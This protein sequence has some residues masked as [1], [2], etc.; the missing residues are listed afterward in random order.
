MKL[1]EL[2]S[3]VE[4]LSVQADVDMEIT[5]IYNDSRKV[6]SGGL[7]VAIP[8][9]KDDG[10]KYVKSALESGAAAVIAESP[11]APG[12]PCVVVE[13]ARRALSGLSANFFGRPSNS[14]TV[15]GVTGTNG[16]TT[17]AY[18]VK[19]MLEQCLEAP[20][21][22]IGTNE[23][24]VGDHIREASRTT[25]ESVE[26]H[27]IFSEMRAAGIKHVVMEVSS[28]AL[29]LK[30]VEDVCFEVGVFTNLTREH[31]DFHIT[32]EDYLNS[33]AMLF[34]MCKKGVI[35][36]DD[37]ASR[38]LLEEGSCEFLTFSNDD[39]KADLVAGNIRYFSTKVEFEA[40]ANG[41][42]NRIRLNIP[43]RFSVYNA[44]AT[45]GVG[46]SL[47]IPLAKI[48]E[49]I[50]SC[51]GV[52]GRAEVV[53]TDKDFAVVIDYAHTPDALENAISAFK[54][55]VRGR[56]IVVFGCGGDRDKTKRPLMGSVVGS[57][58]DLSI[59]TSDNPRT[60]DPLSIIEDIVAGMEK[61]DAYIVIPDRTAAIEHA[62]NIAAEGDFI[63]LDGKG[64]ETYQEING[65]KNHMDEREIVKS[66]L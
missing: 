66:F 46:L 16:K 7:F 40:L 14:M 50:Q 51:H 52:K 35:N 56:M 44:L 29:K 57:L 8:G 55:F 32:M 5:G 20:V 4:T 19:E 30:R 65:Q 18:L 23:I 3:G 60:E 34:K 11:C 28:H 1:S 39:M 54:E 33:K 58:A 42:M 47:G 24:I 22:L 36:F 61:K 49:A 15:I 37:R 10:A 26:I 43:G 12:V 21:G 2:L 13:D 38:T 6:E 48:S 64:H 31:L 27:S 9:F 25:P 62:I 59:V 63:L 45:V 53:P 17:T 41:H